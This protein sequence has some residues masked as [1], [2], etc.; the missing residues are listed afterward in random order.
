VGCPW[1]TMRANRRGEFEVALIR[2]R[3]RRDPASVRLPRWDVN[4]ESVQLV[5]L[6]KY[7]VLERQLRLDQQRTIDKACGCAGPFHVWSQRSYRMWRFRHTPPS[8]LHS[9]RSRN[10]AFRPPLVREYCP[11]RSLDRKDIYSSCKIKHN[12]STESPMSTFALSPST[13]LRT[14]RRRWLCHTV[15][16]R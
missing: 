4:I 10:T 5:I 12:T 11:Q 16:P 15:A 8:S 1:R 13:N 9:H 6:K 14:L 3:S 2:I 7:Y